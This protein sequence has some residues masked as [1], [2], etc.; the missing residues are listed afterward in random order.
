MTTDYLALARSLAHSLHLQVPPIAVC[1]TNHVPA[2]VPAFTGRA[3]AGCVFWQE[4]ARGAFATSAGDHD[5]CAIGTFTHNLDATAAH[6]ADRRDALRVFADL[7]YVR[8]QDIPLIPVLAER[9]RH[10][11][12]APLAA[13][14]LPPDVVVLFV[15]AAQTLV[16][17]E[18][19][20]SVD[21]GRPP[22]MGRPACAVVPQVV[23]QNAAALSLGCCGA[24]AY[25]DVLADDVAIF[26]L[27]GA[28]L[29]AYAARIV[30][31]AKANSVLAAFH[32][33]RRQDVEAGGNPTVKQSL[34]RLS[35][36]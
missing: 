5:L 12:Y 34:E 29:D 4:A 19:A 18:A 13:T 8:P 32:T 17:V 15:R 30:E 6:E 36:R 1:L 14:P 9:R 10:V 24:R 22:A 25:L 7:G 33:L 16:L 35:A 27:P 3:P 11:V 31:L 21:G 20:E 26:A 2:G 28:R 23:N